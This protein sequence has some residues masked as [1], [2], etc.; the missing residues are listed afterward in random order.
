M[1]THPERLHIRPD[2][3]LPTLVLRACVG[4][5]L[6]G[7]A[8]LVPGISGGTM[9]LAA[10]VYPQ[11][12]NSIAEV[13]TCKFKQ[14]SL[15]TLGTVGLSV[16]LSILLFAGPV[17]DLVVHYRWVMYSLFIGLTLG[18]LP[19]VWKM[20]RPT[21][22]A[23]AG[24]IVGGFLIMGTIAWLQA[25]SHPAAAESSGPLMMVLAGLA[26]AS[27][28]ILPG[29]SGGYLLLVLGVYVPIL[30]A[31]SNFVEALKAKDMAA[32]ITPGTQVILP[33]G[34][35]V[36]VGILAVS[37]ILQWALD[38]F[39]KPTLGALLGFLVG[40]VIGL[41]PFQRG[42]PP[43]IGSLFKGKRVTQDLL[44]TLEPHKYPTEYFSPTGMQIAAAVGLVGLGFVL[45]ALIARWGDNGPQQ[46]GTSA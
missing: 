30:T 39:A 28:M 46:L 6:M 35:G 27:A 20:A 25:S 19:V 23:L 41:W 4:G 24:G 43:Q 44:D 11:F 18:G 8:N 14:T 9:L 31:I 37:N 26:G 16:I 15:L 32:L 2:P 45:T 34:I 7:L 12:I 5:I 13:S 42:I 21:T 36:V 40:A 3:P 1:S 10:G 33:V 38:R 17:R 22:P 29:I